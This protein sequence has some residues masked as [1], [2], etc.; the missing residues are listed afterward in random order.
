MKKNVLV[1][2]LIA[3]AIFAM[4]LTVSVFMCYRNGNYEGSMLV[5]YASMIIAFSLIFVAVKN[6]R[7]KLNGGTVTFGKAFTI[8]LYISL[9]ASTIYVGVWL[10]EYYLFIPDFMDKYTEH[11]LGK[12]KSEGATQAEMTNQMAEM[13]TYKSMY[14]NPLMVILLTYAEVLP[15]GLIISLISALL[16]KR[17]PSPNMLA[18]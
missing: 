6:F 11:M 14:Q 8:G 10:V 12:L 13:E 3:G 18:A 17:K 2:G 15:I 9:L 4:M 16:L 5:G 1:C 7:D